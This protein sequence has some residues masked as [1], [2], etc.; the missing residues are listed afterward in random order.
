[1]TRISRRTLLVGAGGG[2]VALGTAGVLVN[3][4]V[5]PGRVRAY[6]LLGLDGPD[7][8]IP[9]VRPGQRVDG[10]FVSQHRGGVRTGWSLSA[11]PGHDP[12]GL[13][14][15]VCLHGARADHT[16]AFDHLGVD[17]FL[18]QAVA[19]GVPPFVV[20]SVDGGSAS[21]WHPRADG[22]DASA[23][24]T[25]EL[26]PML[27]ARFRLGSGLGLYGWSMGGYGALRL[28]LRA[29]GV[30]AVAACSP[31]LFASYRAASAGAFDD[32][33]QFDREDLVGQAG[34]FPA[35]PLR[36]DC[37]KGD[38]FYF[39]VRDFVHR[40]P[41]KPAGGFEAGAHTYGYMRRMLP[42]QFGFLGQH[43]AA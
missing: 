18:A 22:T 24:V 34:S 33:A 13:P 38:P 29:P 32:R 14:L 25:D 21:Y 41:R 28:A 1:M 36:V 3:D 8:P 31:A 10:A 11:P 30:T 4:G 42:A 20:A 19:R 23:M 6:E 17:R 9:D 35:V 26:V 39:Q 7:A 2:L 37:G 16:T 27:R 12:A 15:V 40:L 5:L 43:L